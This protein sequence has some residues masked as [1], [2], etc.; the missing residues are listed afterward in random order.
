MCIETQSQIT[1]VRKGIQSY[2]IIRSVGVDESPANRQIFLEAGAVRQIHAFALGVK[3]SRAAPCAGLV[4]D[5]ANINI[6]CGSRGKLSRKC[7]WIGVGVGHRRSGGLVR[8]VLIVIGDIDVPR[9]FFAASSPADG[10]ACSG[11]VAGRHASRLKAAG[12]LLEEEVIKPEIPLI[13]GRV[14]NGHILCFSGI[15][16]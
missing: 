15:V 6:V 4:A 5:G 16:G 7:V 3:D 13:V 14:F 10:G 9:G 2:I 1:L 11:F 8:H 12:A